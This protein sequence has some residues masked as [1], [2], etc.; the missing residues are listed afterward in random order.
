MKTIRIAQIGTGHDHAAA[1]IWSIDRNK[2][3][4]DFV[5]YS[6]CEGDEAKYEYEK[7][8]YEP[9]RRYSTE[10]ILAMKDLDAVAIETTE[11]LSVKYAQAAADRGLH[12]HLDKPGNDN[13][14]DFERLLSTIKRKGKI[15]SMGY[16][17]RFN[18]AVLSAYKLMKSGK[19]GEVYAVEAHMDCSH[20]PE[21]RQ[22]LE[23]FRGG[24]TFY[25]GCHLV[26]L[27][28]KFKGFPKK[29]VPYN[30]AT[31]IDGVT[32]ED[33]GMAVMLYKEGA[34]FIKA[35]A[36][37]TGGFMRRQ[38]VVCGSL[39]TVEIRPLEAFTDKGGS[40]LRSTS[41]ET[42]MK[43]GEIS[44]DWQACSTNRNFEFDRYDPMLRD[45]AERIKTGEQGEYSLEYEARLHRCVLAA[46]GIS[47]D[48][49]GDITL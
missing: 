19:L 2:D 47:C 43:D 24:M 38:L 16:M 32:A 27:V 7:K 13:A 14:E 45:F 20:T 41:K 3:L 6:V 17:Y 23:Q 1:T 48:F 15:L 9:F 25:L 30:F 12:I 34:S 35:C 29:I 4:F 21:K 44:A 22:W 42:L 11:L 40:V 5:G 31:G 26:D 28:I 39:G 33:N 10:E 37:E 49:G 46:C 8:A 18:P 36:V